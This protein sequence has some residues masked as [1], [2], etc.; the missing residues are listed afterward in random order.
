[1]KTNIFI[2]KKYCM[3]KGSGCPIHIWFGTTYNVIKDVRI[4]S[5]CFRLCYEAEN[6]ELDNGIYNHDDINNFDVQDSNWQL[7]IGKYVYEIPTFPHRQLKRAINAAKRLND[8]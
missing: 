1:M 5:K 3:T 2:T 4:L 6:P 8:K 7:K